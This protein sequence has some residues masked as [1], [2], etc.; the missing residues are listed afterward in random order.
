MRRSLFT[1]LALSLVTKRGL[2]YQTREDRSICSVR[3]IASC[4]SQNRPCGL[5]IY[6]VLISL[7][8]AVSTQI[9]RRVFRQVKF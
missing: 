9:S 5:C 2:L 6:R 4:Y 7:E 1:S 3:E 8:A